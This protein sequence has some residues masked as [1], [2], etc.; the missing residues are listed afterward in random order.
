MDEMGGSLAHLAAQ[1]LLQTDNTEAL[2]YYR[3]NAHKTFL[4]IICDIILDI[5]AFSLASKGS[6]PTEPSQ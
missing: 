1:R 6:W 5:A 4:S 3:P 2:L